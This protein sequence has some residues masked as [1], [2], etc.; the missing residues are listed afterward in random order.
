MRVCHWSRIYTRSAMCTYALRLRCRA[1]K[2][3]SSHMK[4]CNQWNTPIDFTHV[5]SWITA[6]CN[7]FCG[8]K[9]DK[10]SDQ[11][12][13]DT[14]DLMQGCS[15]SIANV[16]ELL[17]SCTKPSIKNIQP[18]PYVNVSDVW[19]E[20][21]IRV[22]TRSYLTYFDMHNVSNISDSVSKLGCNWC[23]K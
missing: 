9:M 1:Y 5:L 3:P 16:L 4:I 23:F 20:N 10:P 13:H 14:D 11:F 22:L 18:S 17:Q 7:V 6:S 21:L 8:T 15:N 2:Y 12:N 19:P